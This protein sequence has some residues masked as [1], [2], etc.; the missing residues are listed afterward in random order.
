MSNGNLDA[1]SPP[2]LTMRINWYAFVVLCGAAA[3]IL[4]LAVSMVDPILLLFLKPL[5]TGLLK[6]GD[7]A[8][9]I[10]GSAGIAVVT[11]GLVLP[12]TGLFCYGADLAVWLLF[13]A[14]AELGLLAG[15]GFAVILT[16]VAFAVAALR[17]ALRNLRVPA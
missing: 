3:L 16:T 7:T 17:F 9:L 12:I 6:W 10:L 11:I 15:L 1:A 2:G 8:R 5:N 14:K 13:S 4:E